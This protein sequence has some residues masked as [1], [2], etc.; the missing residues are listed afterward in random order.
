M[1]EEI[2]FALLCFIFIY[3]NKSK[4]VSNTIIYKL[5]FIYNAV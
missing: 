3:I 4:L 5:Y 2:I 1:L